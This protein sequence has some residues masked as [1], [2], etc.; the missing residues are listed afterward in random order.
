[1][2]IEHPA[3]LC[4]KAE[5]RCRSLEMN[6]VTWL[7]LV[8]FREFRDDSASFK[9]YRVVVGVGGIPERLPAAKFSFVAFEGS[10]GHGN[11]FKIGHLHFE[12]DDVAAAQS[13]ENANRAAVIR[14][15]RQ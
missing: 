8:Y 15:E 7:V 1:M 4:G 12:G 3:R 13:R 10:G 9:F 6:D 11:F 2:P 14:G 5:P